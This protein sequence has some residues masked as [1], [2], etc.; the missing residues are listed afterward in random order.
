MALISGIT[1][2]GSMIEKTFSGIGSLIGSVRSAITGDVSP[3]K[4]AEIEA[5]LLELEYN[6]SK[7]QTDINLEEAKN[8]NLFVSG[9][10]PSIG[11]VCSFAL[12]YTFIFYSL[13]EWGLR[14]A[15][16]AIQPPDLRVDYLFELVMAMLG[17]GG[18]RTFEKIKGVA[19]K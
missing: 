19:S 10:R 6:L 17:L 7:L 11:W 14:L 15:D 8:P 5:K 9:W 13:I 1:V 4:K 2:D 16:S 3:E 12:A 18:L